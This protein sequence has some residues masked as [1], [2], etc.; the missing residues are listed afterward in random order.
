MLP[1]PA[2]GLNIRLHG[3]LDLRRTLVVKDDI[4]IIGFAGDP[5][6]SLAE[7]RRKQPA[8]RDVADLVCSI[9]YSAAAALARSG[10]IA[11][12]EHGRIAS[13]L[14]RWRDQAAAAF[15][16]AYRDTLPGL[17]LWPSDPHAADGMLEFFLLEKFFDKM[18]YELTHRPEWL[19]VPLIEILNILSKPVNEA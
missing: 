5:R 3:N 8:A 14:A 18:D 7:R 10:K 6:E 1:E 9:G 11:H 4:F 12:D 17:K 16:S 2:D 19:Q 15:L 13:A